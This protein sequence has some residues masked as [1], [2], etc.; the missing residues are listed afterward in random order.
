MADPRR[1]PKI[2]PIETPLYDPKTGVMHNAWYRYFQG[3]RGQVDN[4]N[5]GVATARA[6]AQAA[7]TA[8]VEAQGTATG[9]AIAVSDL[10][11]QAVAFSATATPPAGA[12]ASSTSSSMTTNSVT[13]AGVGGT[14]PYVSYAWTITGADIAITSASSASTTFLNI[15]TMIRGEER[16]QAATCTITDSAAAT[17]TVT[18][19]VTLYREEYIA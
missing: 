10:A 8:A 16:Q 11:A 17:T 1:E 19:G 12:F 7:R 13:A 18:I 15:G 6:E 3:E 5:S 2:P 9:A 14:P 4:V